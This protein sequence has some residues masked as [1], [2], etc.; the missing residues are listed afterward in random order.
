MR[1]LFA[2]V[3]LRGRPI[4]NTALRILVARL[5]PY[6]HIMA[7][8]SDPLKVTEGEVEFVVPAAGKICKT[9]YKVVGALGGPTSCHPLVAL[10][11]GPGVNHAYLLVLSD[12]TRAHGIP[13]IVYD[14][15]GT[16]TLPTSPRRW[17][18]R[19]SRRNSYSL[20]SSI[21][22]LHILGYRTTTTFWVTH[23]LFNSL[24]SAQG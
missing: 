17:A 3:Q 15:I 1:W 16:E 19:R 23:G 5:F 2:E 22:C 6:T 14:Q 18:T 24:S 4:S 9:W 10:H 7:A 12:L 20:T 21:I 8:L 13:L 11:G